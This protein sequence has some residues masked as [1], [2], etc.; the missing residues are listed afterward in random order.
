MFSTK[1]L[2]KAVVENLQLIGREKVKQTDLM[3]IR[4][5]LLAK[6]LHYM[7]REDEFNRMAYQASSG[8]PLPDMHDEKSVNEYQEAQAGGRDAYG[9]L[10]HSDIALGGMD[11]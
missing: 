5:E 3:I 9:D 1:K 7:R 11:E 4:N 8:A 6:Q 10:Y 2:M